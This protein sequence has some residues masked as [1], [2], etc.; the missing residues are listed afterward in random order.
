MCHY[1]HI[2]F[3]RWVLWFCAYHIQW[4]RLHAAA[5]LLHTICW[6]LIYVYGRKGYIWCTFL[7]EVYKYFNSKVVCRNQKAFS[8]PYWWDSSRFNIDLVPFCRNENFW[9]FMT[10]PLSLTNVTKLLD[11]INASLHQVSRDCTKFLFRDDETISRQGFLDILASVCKG[12]EQPNVLGSLKKDLTG[13]GGG[14]QGE[15]FTLFGGSCRV[16]RWCADPIKSSKSQCTQCKRY[17][18]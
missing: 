7:F 1:T 14:I 3:P 10:P 16:K 6:E 5:E 2:C 12:R 13:G 9:Q 11:Q 4:N 18:I 8:Y 15:K 17:E